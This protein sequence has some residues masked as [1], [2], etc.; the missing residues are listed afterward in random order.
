MNKIITSENIPIKLWL[1]HLEEGALEQARNL[2]N[3]SFAYKHIAIMPDCHVGYG[4]PIGGI[5]A[6]KD[7]IIPNAVG[8]DIGC[9]VCAVKTSL[10]HIKRKNLKKIIA[11]IKQL[12]PTGFNWHKKAQS[13]EKIPQIK[14][15]KYF[16]IVHQEYKKALHQLGT[17]GGGNHFIEIQQGSDGHIWFMVHTGSRNLGKKVADHYNKIAIKINKNLNLKVSAKSQLAFLPIDIFEAKLYKNEMEYSVLFA[18]A[19]RKLII[20][21]IKNVF[22]NLFQQITYNQTIDIAHNYAAREKHFTK[23]VIV[24]RKGAIKAEKGQLGIIPGSQGTKS[25]IVC[26]KGNPESF[27][28]CAHGAGR[29][30]GRRQAIKTLNLNKEIFSLNKKNILHSINKKKDLDEAPSAY[31]NIDMVMK[32]Q[33]DLL[34]IVIELSPIA[35]IKG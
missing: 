19:N 26:G 29:K 23:H 18:L 16:P 12:V 27:M 25:Y 22:S 3:L 6:A 20:Q 11:N 14:H 2:A 9:G 21:V 7:V 8:V 33:T 30:L 31:K 4:M 32:N 10:K 13:K 24:H 5:L 1:D 15:K 35:V 34:D 28:S 17:L